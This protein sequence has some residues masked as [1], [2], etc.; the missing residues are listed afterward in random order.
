MQVLAGNRLGLFPAIF[1]GE[2]MRIMTQ[3]DLL[4][5]KISQKDMTGLVDE[6]INDNV[7]LIALHNVMQSSHKE[8][9]TEELLEGRFQ[10]DADF[11]I[12]M[13]NAAA[14]L[15]Y[16]LRKKGKACSWVWMP[17]NCK[18]E[19]KV[20]GTAFLCIDRSIRCL[21][22]FSIPDSVSNTVLGIQLDNLEDWF[23]CLSMESW[24]HP[25]E[26]FLSQ[27]KILNCC[28]ASKRL[29]G[30]VWL[31]GDFGISDSENK[32]SCACMVAGGW[33][34]EGYGKDTNYNIWYSA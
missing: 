4:Q 32:E 2:I 13:D 7:S 18:S 17:H 5:G 12:R 1:V 22:R 31:L 10:Q 14:L 16:A 3:E 24:D 33:K 30:T 28:I 20:S 29:C 23:Y 26:N 19:S 6:I 34:H 9:A 11:E 15:A 21:D 25:G 8:L 27:W